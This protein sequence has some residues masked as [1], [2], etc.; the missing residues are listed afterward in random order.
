M[1]IKYIFKKKH[2]QLLAATFDFLGGVF[3]FPFKLFWRNRPP[4][5]GKILIIRLDHIGDVVFS[6][7]VAQ[8]LKA[9]YK[10]AKVTFLVASWAKDIVIN[11][12]YVDEVVCYDAPWFSRDQKKIV[13]LKSFFRL[14]KQL[15]NQQ[16]DIGFDLRGDIRHILLMVLAGV[17]FRIGYGITGGG[18]LLHRQ[19]IYRNGVHAIEHNLD[20]IR[21]NGVNII[22]DKPQLYSCAEGEEK[23]KE[24]LRSNKISAGN[25]VVVIH[26]YGGYPS[27]NWLDDRFADLTK[28]LFAEYRAKIIFVG[29]SEDKNSIDNIIRIKGTPA[30][31]AAGNFGLTGLFSILKRARLFIGVDSGPSHIAAAA[32]TPTVVLYSGTN[33]LKEWGPLE[34]N[35]RV[36]QKDIHCKGCENP[37]C[38]DNICMDLISVEDVM[39]AVEEVTDR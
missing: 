4:N 28:A 8:N 35:V 11:N 10:G 16:Y 18:F 12:P 36:I 38:T 33:S 23:A 17:K 31:N 13:D 24:F 7:V 3:I 14:A 19:A 21:D 34:D 29:V 20:L 22:L 27:K 9:H 37:D 39:E 30:I 32:G 26:P 25:F 2:Y 5:V 1:P 6:T 15:R